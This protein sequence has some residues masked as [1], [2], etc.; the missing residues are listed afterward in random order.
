M[1]EAKDRGHTMGPTKGQGQGHSSNSH[2]RPIDVPIPDIQFFQQFNLQIQGQ[3]MVEVKVQGHEVGLTSYRLTSF[4]YMAIGHSISRMR[5]FQNLTLKI[6]GHCHS[7]R[8]HNGSNFPDSK[9]PWI[10]AGQMTIICR[11][12][13]LASKL[14]QSGFLCYLGSLRFI[15]INLHILDTQ[16]FQNL[17]IPWRSRKLYFIGIMILCSYIQTMR[18]F[19]RINIV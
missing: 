19:S 3:V 18:R 14:H 2:S 9:D 16:L 11:N 4:R 13:G 6:Q 12:V 8:S 7:S 15:P 1:G 10:D 5:L 17:K